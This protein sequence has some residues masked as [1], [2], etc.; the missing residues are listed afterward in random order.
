MAHFASLPTSSGVVR[1][2][3][4][5]D[6]TMDTVLP[7]L[8]EELRLP[9]ASLETLTHLELCLSACAETREEFGYKAMLRLLATAA[10][11]THLT[12][13]F[14]RSARN[15]WD[16]GSFPHFPS[17]VSIDFTGVFDEA[18]DFVVFLRKHA[19]TRRRRDQ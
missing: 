2:L 14:E 8:G 18:D 19:R 5:A 6:E 11:L 13:R 1:R 16:L 4:I 15:W 12:V 9:L 3:H 17:L 10:N 7:S